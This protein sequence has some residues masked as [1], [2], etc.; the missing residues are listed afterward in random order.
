MVWHT[1]ASGHTGSWLQG[2]E[3]SGTLGLSLGL[4]SPPETHFASPTKGRDPPP[5]LYARGLGPVG[6]TPAGSDQLEAG[7]TY[8]GQ[9]W[10][11]TKALML[12]PVWRRCPWM[13]SWVPPAWGPRW[14]LRLSRTGSWETRQAR[15][16]IAIWPGISS[17]WLQSLNPVPHCHAPPGGALVPS[18]C[19]LVLSPSSKP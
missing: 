18:L 7:A 4:A 15:A 3:R 5:P 11:P 10:L 8:I 19:R 14:G 1:M 9:G 6:S 12:P 16:G 17:P 2:G 13:V